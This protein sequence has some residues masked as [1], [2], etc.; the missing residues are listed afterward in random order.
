MNTNVLHHNA[1][2]ILNFNIV[3]CVFQIIKKNFTHV[4]LVGVMEL[5]DTTYVIIVTIILIN[6]NALTLGV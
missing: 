3:I 4:V 2:T 1:I 5:P 6:K